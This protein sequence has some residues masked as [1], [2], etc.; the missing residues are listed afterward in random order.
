MTTEAIL[1]SYNST[2][3]APEFGPYEEES[4][5]SLALDYP[6]F[7]SSVVDYI[8]PDLFHRDECRWVVK[9]LIDIYAQ[10]GSLP[11]R[12]LFKELMLKKIKVK[13]PHEKIMAIIN[14]PSSLKEVPIVKN[15]IL[16]WAKQKA[17]GLLFSEEAAMAHARGDYAFL[18]KLIN[19]ASKVND[20]GEGGFWLLKN[21]KEL[22]IDDPASHRTTG[23]KKL[24]EKLNS[25]GP[26]PKEVVC[27]MAP[28]NVGKSILLCNNAITSLRGPGPDGKLGQNV[29]LV[30]FELSAKKTAAR[31]LGSLTGINLVDFKNHQ[32]YIERNINSLSTNYNKQLL[33]KELPCDECSVTHIYNIVDTERRKSGWVPDVIILDYM[34]LMISR[35]PAYNKDD[36]TRQKQI[37][38]E[39]RG[40]AKNLNVLVFTATQ[41]NRSG[42][43]ED[44]KR[45]TLI[46]MDSAAE[47]FGKLFPMDYIISLN[48]STSERNAEVSTLRFYI[49]KNR[50]GPRN[51]MVTC[52]IDY[53]N[54][55][56]REL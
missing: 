44:D 49:I 39:I 53:N 50:N 9:N 8:K 28:T 13:D 16:T 35:N 42:A 23:F 14:R 2:L 55:Q 20:P 45:P 21:Y 47:S 56:M 25:G 29:L 54:M 41:T 4:I 15:T 30:T 48:Q 1:N 33:I 32:D 24:D 12:L 19:D 34:D 46:T 6:D 38:T 37:S 17:Y 27:W 11:S 3:S 31:C 51:E 26:S 18:E 10:Y 40:L 5:I 36:Y 43:K 7:F 52:E 22:M